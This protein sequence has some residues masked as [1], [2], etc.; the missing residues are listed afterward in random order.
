M[1]KPFEA[2]RENL[3]RQ[4]VAPRHVRA[5]LTELREHLADI[6]EQECASGGDA[7]EAL[8]RARARLGDDDTLAQA[9]LSRRKRSLT[10]RA[11]W[12]VLGVLQ[13]L[14]LIILCCVGMML[15]FGL[16]M[17]AAKILVW[18]ELLHW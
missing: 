17:V 6:I 10:A 13:S 5:Y 11:P 18:P 12:L 8:A 16:L 3:L 4:G 2:L 14:A 7:H 15:C 9:M 1:S